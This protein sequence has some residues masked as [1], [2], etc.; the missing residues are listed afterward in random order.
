MITLTASAPD[1]LS[2]STASQRPPL[3]VGLV[4]HRW[5]PDVDKLT[6]VLRD[7]IDRAAG[8]G[9]T[10]VFLPEIT[11]L[12]YPADTPAGRNPGDAAEDLTGGPTFALAAEAAQ[13]NGIFVHASLYEKAPA[14]DGLGYNTAILVSPSGELVGRTRK[15]HIPISAGYY[16]DTY[17]RPGPADDDPY[18]VYDPEGLGAR[19]GLPTCWD[20]WFP[21]VARNYS[22]GGAEMVVYPTAIGSEPVFPAFD[23]QPLWQQVIV[24]NGISSGL[25]MVVPNRT[26]DE[27]T[28]SFYGSS[29]I[30]DPYGRVLVQAPRDEEAVLVADLDLDQR[31]DWL[32]LF[33]FLVTRRP[34][35]YGRLTAPV[36]PAH[37]YGDGHEATPVVK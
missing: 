19:I 6:K 17:F 20:E 21:E 8:A 3:R 26:G 30:S 27:G 12:R 25:F 10:A 32:E 4:Q 34:D 23:T 2:R 37:P 28:V 9:A 15:M 29:F 35:S 24:A 13:A 18:P 14:A 33:P 22:L 11:L 5:R 16:E 31:R 1:S 36:D 7:G